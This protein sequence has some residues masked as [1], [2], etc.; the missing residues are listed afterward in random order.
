MEYLFSPFL[1]GFEISI[2]NFFSV[3]F[4]NIQNVKIFLRN[5]A[6]L[7]VLHSS[8]W[9]HLPR[10]NNKMRDGRIPRMLRVRPG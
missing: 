5:M 6:P 2:L 8:P 4:L 9:Q 7:L 3:L 1:F 10:F